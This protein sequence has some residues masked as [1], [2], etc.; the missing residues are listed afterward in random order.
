M[1]FFQLKC[2]CEFVQRPTNDG[3]VTAKKGVQSEHDADPGLQVDSQ[4]KVSD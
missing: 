1:Q 4:V 2:E 3:E